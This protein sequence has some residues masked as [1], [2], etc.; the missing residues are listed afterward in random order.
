MLFWLLIL[1]FCAFTNCVSFT[2]YNNVIIFRHRDSSLLL[3][4]IEIKLL[5]KNV[6]NSTN[7]FLS[8]LKYT[9]TIVNHIEHYDRLHINVY[10]EGFR[11]D[12]YFTIIINTFNNTEN[13]LKLKLLNMRIDELSKKVDTINKKEFRMIRYHF[14]ILDHLIC[15]GLDQVQSCRF[16]DD[17][18]VLCVCPNEI[19]R[20]GSIWYDFDRSSGGFY[21]MNR[22]CTCAFSF[23]RSNKNMFN[24]QPIMLFN[25]KCPILGYR[26]LYQQTLTY[27]DNYLVQCATQS[28]D[29]VK[30]IKNMCIT[31]LDFTIYFESIR[32]VQSFDWYAFG[33]IEKMSNDII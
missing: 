8:F 16:T 11:I 6:F 22:N 4:H 2:E 12:I 5:T 15:E 28:G 7:T 24:S 17:D 32:I 1:S 19:L 10:N 26:D 27:I 31:K 23:N 29:I 18:T 9:E 25:T 14:N 33:N 3:D 20:N 21:S 13:E 30:Q